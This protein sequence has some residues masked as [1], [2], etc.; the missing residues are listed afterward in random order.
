MRPPVD[1]LAEA[2]AA[3]ARIVRFGAGGGPPRAEM[4][5]EPEARDVNGIALHFRQR[6]PVRNRRNILAGLLLVLDL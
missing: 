2:A 5:P 1:T 4:L 6:E 3:F